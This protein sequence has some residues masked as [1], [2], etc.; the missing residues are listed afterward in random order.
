MKIVWPTTCVFTTFFDM[1]SSNLICSSF[2]FH[3][4]MIFRPQLVLFYGVI[5]ILR[6]HK[7]KDFLPPPPPPPLPQYTFCIGK[8]VLFIRSV[9]F[10]DTREI[11]FFDVLCE[12]SGHNPTYL[13][14]F[15]SLPPPWCVRTMWM[16]PIW[17]CLLQVL[18]CGIFLY[19]I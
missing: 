17:A 2:Y 15:T 19:S 9:R 13:G 8:M 14:L 6:M 4:I 10:G 5:Y 12:F 1:F 7:I 16:A 3:H 18:I 11:A